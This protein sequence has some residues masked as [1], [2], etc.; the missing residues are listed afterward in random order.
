MRSYLL[1]CLSKKTKRAQSK[2]SGPPQRLI[3]WKSREKIGTTVQ[4]HNQ[5]RAWT[6]NAGRGV[7]K[8]SSGVKETR[9]F[10]DR[11]FPDLLSTVHKFDCGLKKKNLCARLW[12]TPPICIAL[13]NE[14]DRPFATRSCP[15]NLILLPLGYF[16]NFR[17][18]GKSVDVILSLVDLVGKSHREGR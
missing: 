2:L 18:D 3:L 6:L 13:P 14:L 7:G 15:N 8:C 10:V 12:W 11:T 1:K 5:L 4:D 17:I 16:S 9:T